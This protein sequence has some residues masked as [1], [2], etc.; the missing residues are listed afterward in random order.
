MKLPFVRAVVTVV[1]C[2]VA[3]ATIEIP[4]VAAQNPITAAREAYRKAQEEAKRK[5]QEEARR[6]QQGQP[7]SP[8]ATPA[9]AQP[10]GAQSGSPNVRQTG[11]VGAATFSAQETAR[12]AAAAAFLDVAGLKL[13]SPVGE[14]E[15]VLRGINSRFQIQPT[16]QIVWPD[17]RSNIEVQPPPT[18]PRSLQTL[19][20]TWVAGSNS[21]AFVIQAAVHPNPPVITSIERSFNYAPGAGP[22]FTTIVEGLRKKYGPESAVQPYAPA[23]VFRARWFFDDRAQ[24]LRGNLAAQLFPSCME[25]SSNAI[26]LCSTL[27]VLNVSVDA[28]QSGGV[29]ALRVQVANSQLLRNAD[30]V[31]Q[32]YLRQVDEERA[33]R[34]QKDSSQRQG[35]K[36]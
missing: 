32:A 17:D 35:P 10:A 36:L 26:E 20:A 19:Q 3:A 7:G 25:G 28:D 11:N 15:K 12:L 14:A 24:P 4:A 27:T 8:A 33:K 9:S 29:I 21:E 31:T 18:A 2:V 23:N 13:G 22:N 34:Q 30:E 16:I 1:A 6:R 5:G